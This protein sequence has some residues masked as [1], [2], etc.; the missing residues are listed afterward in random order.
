MAAKKPW[1]RI[2]GG[3]A[4]ENKV[5]GPTLRMAPDFDDRL[6]MPAQRDVRALSHDGHGDLPVRR[7]CLEAGCGVVTA[8]RNL[9]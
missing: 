5:A 7:G 8:F 1:T 3:P 2:A 6:A 4:R 9:F